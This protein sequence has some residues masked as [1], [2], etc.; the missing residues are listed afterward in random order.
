MDTNQFPPIFL[1]RLARIFPQPDQYQ[2]ILSAFTTK[3]TIAIRVNTLK[4][5]PEE[6]KK[7]IVDSGI[8]FSIIPWY[9]HAILLKNV[10]AKNLTTLPMYKEGKIYIQSLSSMIPALIL[11]PDKNDK[12][13]DMAAAPG[14]KTTQLAAMMENQGEIVANDMSHE[15]LYKLKAN[16]TLQGVTNTKPLHGAGQSLWQKYP[17]YFDK[18][19]VDA[20]CSMEGRFNLDEA[21]SFEDWS[22]KKIKRLSKLQKWLLRSAISATKVDG[23]IIYSTCTLAPEENEEVINWILE[24]ESKTIVLESIT[25]PH[26]EMTDGMTSWEDTQFS[27]ELKHTKRIMPSVNMEGF[28]IAKIRKINS[29]V[30]HA[31]D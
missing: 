3:N 7:I 21:E 23:L 19:L 18:V 22:M 12:I 5:T 4:A 24:K 6:V 25:V 11:N 8:S 17:E 2:S 27:P 20:P 15:R 31:E 1:E 28:F 13:L 30:R 14:S 29:N 26:L 16:L 10:L 9:P